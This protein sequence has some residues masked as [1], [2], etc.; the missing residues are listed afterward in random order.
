MNEKFK[1]PFVIVTKRGLVFGASSVAATEGKFIV[2]LKGLEHH[3]DA[4]D[5][6]IAYEVDPRHPAVR[7]DPG[8]LST[9]TALERLMVE[10]ADGGAP[11]AVVIFGSG[12]L[13]LTLLP[14]RSTN[15][16]DTIVTDEFAA[17]V[18]DRAPE[19][20]LE[21][22]LLDE[23]LLALLGSWSK[24]TSEVI[25]PL[26][27]SLRM[28]HPLDTVMQKL[29]RFSDQRFAEKD[30]GDIDAVVTSLQ[31][32]KETLIEL[33]TENPARYARLSGRFASQADAI[34]RNTQ[35]FLGKYLPELDFK[36]IVR[37]TGDRYVEGVASAGMLP[38]VPDADFRKF[39]KRAPQIGG[40]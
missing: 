11:P 35:W 37:L 17:F 39:L 31:P 6:E 32:T 33:L 8:I 24:R 26:G 10:F 5:I 7:I 27:C 14:E 4:D 3:L 18:N 2:H 16:L 19:T 20:D 21:V 13:A 23:R 38:K 29:L 9:V 36:D 40:D 1:G 25:G 28:V 12:S 22:E 30:Q 15:D 34:E